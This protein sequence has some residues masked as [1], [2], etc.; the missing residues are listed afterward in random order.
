MH[1][2]IT[3]K[4]LFGTDGIRGKVGQFPITPDFVLRIGWALGKVLAE[5]A[6]ATQPP[7]VIIG[8]DTR[9]SGYF[10]ESALEAGLSA[11]GVGV[12][13]LGPMPTP[14]IAFFTQHL[15][16]AAGIVISA[17]HNPYQD[18]G[19]K[20]FAKDGKK[21]SDALERAI[22]T[23]VHEPLTVVEANKLGKAVRYDHAAEDYIEF[24]CQAVNGESFAGFT[25]VLDCANGAAYHVAPVILAKLGLQVKTL[26]VSPNGVN[27]NHRCGSTSP[28]ALQ[29]AVEAEQADFG[30]ALDG[31]GDRVIFV[32]HQGRIVDG[33]NLLYVLTKYRKL[34]GTLNGGVVGT[35]MTNYGLELKLKEQGIPFARANVGDRYV[36]QTL[37]EHGWELGG[38]A[39]GHILALDKTTTGDGII[40]A[41][42]VL[43]ALVGLQQKLADL[44][45]EWDQLPQVLVNVLMPFHCDPMSFVP[46]KAIVEQAEKELAGSGRVLLRCSGTE[47]LVRVMVE[48]YDKNK[49]E[50]LAYEIAS[51]VEQTLTNQQYAAPA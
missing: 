46:I 2:E 37:D 1:H 44:V 36:L 20:F 11:A 14:G 39:S 13:L 10:L 40:S 28:Q 3:A 50:A 32:D 48:G 8:K 49:V 51:V 15:D 4:R 6:D 16:A 21:F 22:E 33:D 29:R 45:N 43:Q 47:P 42:L 38:E 17:S 12:V 34:A 19:L 9:S 30:I 31:D 27:I 7:K 41:L 18:N 25:C 23:V 5:H 26:G 35:L 24:C